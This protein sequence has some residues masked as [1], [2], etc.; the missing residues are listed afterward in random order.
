MRMWRY[1]YHAFITLATDEDEGTASHFRNF[2]S[3]HAK[4]PLVHIG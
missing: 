3:P 1:S 4:Q 2:T